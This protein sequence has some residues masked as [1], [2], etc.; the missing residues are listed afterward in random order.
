MSKTDFKND[1]FN[2]IENAHRVKGL[3]ILLK[4]LRH[5][6]TQESN[7]TEME[8][9]EDFLLRD[10]CKELRKFQDDLKKDGT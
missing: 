5:K 1:E 8:L 7:G 10:K 9:A 2:D 4:F 6:D 3:D